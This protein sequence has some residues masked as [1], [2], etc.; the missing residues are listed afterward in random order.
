MKEFIIG[1]T[2][3][4]KPNYNKLA[5]Q[6]LPDKTECRTVYNTYCIVDLFDPTHLI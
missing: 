4:P 1:L 5:C 3:K 2:T 6:E